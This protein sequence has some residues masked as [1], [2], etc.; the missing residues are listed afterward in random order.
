MERIPKYPAQKLVTCA[1]DTNHRFSAGSCQVFRWQSRNEADRAV[2]RPA[3]DSRKR[4][5]SELLETRDSRQPSE[6]VHFVHVQNGCRVSSSLIRVISQAK[7]CLGESTLCWVST[8]SLS[9][10][11]CSQQG[12]ITFSLYYW[13]Y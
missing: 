4:G 10:S 2:K 5:H 13:M 9:L 12:D 1:S 3:R 8:L 7:E 6:A 11:L